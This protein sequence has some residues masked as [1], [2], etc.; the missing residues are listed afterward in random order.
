MLKWCAYCQQFLEEAP[1]YEK[2]SITHGIC[3]S[4]VNKGVFFDAGNNSRLKNLVQFQRKLYE[5]GRSGEIS[6]IP[7][8]LEESQKLG[9]RPIDL[10]F[11]LIN[12]MLVHIGNLWEKGEISVREEHRFSNFSSSLL[13]AIQMHPIESKAPEGTKILL[14]SADKNYHTFGTR[15]LHLWLTA[16]GYYS[17]LITPG[18]PT[19]ELVSY[20]Q[21]FQPEF[22]GISLSLKSQVEYVHDYLSA[23]RCAKYQPKVIL[24]GYAIKSLA[25]TAQDI[26]E[27]SFVTKTQ[28][29]KAILEN[30]PI[31]KVS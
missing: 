3:R 20:I 8:L 4:C 9:T 28:Q 11:G 13:D 1:P 5:A 18:L 7:S 10:I 6:E 15:V 24:G 27:V 16:E 14:V 22:L 19:Q 2:L 31:K 26:S 30:T 23:S 17:E 12:P 25:V 29:L 21:E